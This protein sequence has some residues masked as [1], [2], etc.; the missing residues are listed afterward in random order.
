MLLR[1]GTPYVAKDVLPLE[2]IWRRASRLA[3]E[4]KRGEVEYEDRLRKLK[5]PTL[6]TRRLFLSLVECY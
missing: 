2:R 6:E 3:L 4:Q 1:P 5:W